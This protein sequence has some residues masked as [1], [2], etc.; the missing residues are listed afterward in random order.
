MDPFT[1]TILGPRLE[2]QAQYLRFFQ[3]ILELWC[4]KD[5]NKQKRGRDWPKF[6][7]NL[8]IVSNNKNELNIGEGRRKE[9]KVEKIFEIIASRR[10]YYFVL[11]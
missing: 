7:K 3:F 1:H 8:L 2:A 9:I 6:E 11:G 5:E 10:R 4:E